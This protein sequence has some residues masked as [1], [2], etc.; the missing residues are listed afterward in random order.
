VNAR[1]LWDMVT[2]REPIEQQIGE[3]L[4]EEARQFEDWAARPYYPRFLEW[5]KAESSKTIRVDQHMGSDVIRTNTFKEILEH[6]ER[7]ARLAR[8]VVGG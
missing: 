8:R 3:E 1:G 6:L 2:R 5:L 7:K 4:V